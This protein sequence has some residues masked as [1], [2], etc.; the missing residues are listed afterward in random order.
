[1]KIKTLQQP[2]I[3]AGIGEPIVL[4]DNLIKRPQLNVPIYS[5]KHE[6]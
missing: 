5:G 3:G 6:D 4:R 1:M 2:D